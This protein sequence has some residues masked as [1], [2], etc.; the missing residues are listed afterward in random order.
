[1]HGAD[2][3][4]APLEVAECLR[5]VVVRTNTAGYVAAFAT[6]LVARNIEVSLAPAR[7]QVSPIQAVANDAWRPASDGEAEPRHPGEVVEL[8]ISI[9]RMATGDTLH[10]P[11]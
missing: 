4:G 9:P 1:M 11:A 6:A 5:P 2:Q 8:D 10:L 7:E 3:Q